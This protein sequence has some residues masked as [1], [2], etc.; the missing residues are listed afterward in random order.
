MADVFISYAREDADT[1]ERLHAALVQRQLSV[2]W[3]PELRNAEPYADVIANELQNAKAVIALWTPVSVASKWVKAEAGKAD[4]RGVL[5]HV[6][7]KNLTA[8]RVPLPWNLQHHDD[9]SGWVGAADDRR[10]E[11]LL[12]TVERRVSRTVEH[13][14]D[15]APELA[16]PPPPPPSPP[17]P[18][19][20][21][22]APAS[23]PSQRW[24][25]VAVV[26]ALAAL[27]SVVLWAIL[28]GDSDPVTEDTSTPTG[29]LADPSRATTEAPSE[30]TT[31]EAPSE[32]TS[33]IR[34]D[35]LE[36]GD[37][38]TA[39]DVL[40]SDDGRHTLEMTADGRLQAAT[41]GQPWW[42]SDPSGPPGS[43]A[44]MQIDGNLVVYPSL[45]QMSQGDDVWNSGSAGRPGSYYLVVDSADGRGFIAIYS[46]TG[47]RVFYQPDDRGAGPESAVVPNVAGL[48]ES[49][50]VARLERADFDVRVVRV[51]SA[52]VQE[53]DA[54][55]TDPPGGTEAPVGSE[56]ELEVS[57]GSSGNPPKVPCLIGMTDTAAEASLHSA[58]FNASTELV[59][60]P[61]GSPDVGEVVG[62]SPMCE[63]DADSGSTVVIRVGKEAAPP[64]TAT[65]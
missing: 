32:T 11:R 28:Q 39:G 44:A 45:T 15:P 22:P 16:P 17:P 48:N 62:Q 38:L 10:L 52:S 23:A 1:A 25:L 42:D 4:D 59:D 58:G 43:V 6:R 53:G 8:N 13:A 27:T 7:D 24:W 54:I 33:V 41:D 2:W 51:S 3:D 56:V 20:P 49:S 40:E 12:D 35:R 37:I 5:L 30:T 19:V 55:R 21:P 31:T 46:E 57:R 60:V 61:F 64:S 18:P 47:E 36:S 9:L 50:A 34:R 63:S 29:T 65:P 26:V 14:P